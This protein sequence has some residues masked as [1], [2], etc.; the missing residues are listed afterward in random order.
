MSIWFWIAVIIAAALAAILVS[1]LGARSRVDPTQVSIDAAV[2][3]EVKRLYAG[4]D[5]PQAV[6]TLRA[7][8]GLGLA[9][10]VRIADKLGAAEKRPTAPAIAAGVEQA[11]IGP[12]HRDE[13]RSLVAAGRSVEAIGLVR[14]LTGMPLE[15]ARDFV[16]RL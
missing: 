1:R 3:A 2:A 7:A 16:D 9:D 8:T 6:N 13:L 15:D 10:A 14:Q 5:K 12:D 11:G 4:G